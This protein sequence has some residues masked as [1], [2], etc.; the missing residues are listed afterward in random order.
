MLSIYLDN[1]D[2]D[3]NDQQSNQM[4]VIFSVCLTHFTELLFCTENVLE[5]LKSHHIS[6]SICDIEED[7]AMEWN[8]IN[9]IA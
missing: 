5:T 1:D 9:A 7:Q 4:N 3:D 8:R 6:D 2:D